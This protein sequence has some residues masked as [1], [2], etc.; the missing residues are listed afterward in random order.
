MSELGISPVLKT[1]D[2]VGGEVK[3]DK[4]TF[5]SQF[6]CGMSE[7]NN[8]QYDADNYLKPN[9]HQPTKFTNSHRR[10]AMGKLLGDH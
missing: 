5:L 10:P 4:K 7:E 2:H 3:I 1:L 8:A 9:S 6:L